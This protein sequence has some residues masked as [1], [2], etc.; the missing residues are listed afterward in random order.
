[1]NRYTVTGVFHN[2]DYEISIK[3]DE[4]EAPNE[5]EANELANKM[6]LGKVYYGMGTPELIHEYQGKHKFIDEKSIEYCKK[7]EPRTNLTHETLMGFPVYTNED[8]VEVS[9]NTLIKAQFKEAIER[10]KDYI[11]FENIAYGIERK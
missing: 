9:L 1:M 7:A 4:I 10:G 2:E 8:Y 6:N 5:I 3:V 11:F